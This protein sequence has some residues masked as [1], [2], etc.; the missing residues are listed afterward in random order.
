MKFIIP[1]TNEESTDVDL[2]NNLIENNMINIVKEEDKINID[3]NDRVVELINNNA[4]GDFDKAERIIEAVKD[5]YGINC[6]F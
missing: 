6:D 3:I 4:L 1:A 5:Y 2:Y